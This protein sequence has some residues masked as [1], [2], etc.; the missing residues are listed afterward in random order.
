MVSYGL[1]GRGTAVQFP[2]STR[3]FSFLY[4]V[5]QG[6]GVHP[7]SWPMNAGTSSPGVKHLQDRA[8]GGLLGTLQWTSAFRIM[9]RYQGGWA[10]G[11]FSGLCSVMLVRHV[12]ASCPSAP[13]PCHTH[14]A[15]P[16]RRTYPGRTA[17]THRTSLHRGQQTVQHV[18]PPDA[19]PSIFIRRT[20][21]R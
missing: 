12:F 16:T 4:S 3:W 5:Q 21:S 9:T 18:R 20:S 10:T 19:L 8:S 1:A 15:R 17:R 6:S 7:A 2:I 11:G 13:R 14:R